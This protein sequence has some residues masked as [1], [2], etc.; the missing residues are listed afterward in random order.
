MEFLCLIYWNIARDIILQIE[1]KH[2]G[3]AVF[4][5]A[6]LLGIK[7]NCMIPMIKN[8]KI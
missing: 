3:T 5:W 4:Q 6:Q 2:T 8:V 7:H 1:E